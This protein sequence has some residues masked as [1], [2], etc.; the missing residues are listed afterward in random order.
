MPTTKN[1][2]VRGWHLTNTLPGHSK[3]YTVLVSDTGVVTTSWGRIG[4]AGQSKVQKFPTLEDAQDVGLRQVYAK[5]SGGY[6]TQIENFTFMATDDAL[7][8]ACLH[9]DSAILDQAFHLAYK[10]QP[11]DGGKEAVFQHYQSFKDQAQKLL[12]KQGDVDL[13]DLFTEYEQVKAA[14]DELDAVH[15]ETATTMHLVERMLHTALLGRK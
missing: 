7:A 13:A 11:A 4:T 8:D 5:K 12:D 15:A 6:V 14:W 3:F 2:P 9:N 1:V 10:E